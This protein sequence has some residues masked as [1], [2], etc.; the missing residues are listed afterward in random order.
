MGNG[1]NGV[2]AGNG[3]LTKTGTG[4]LQ[5]GGA[6]VFTGSLTVNNGQLRMANAQALGD[7]TVNTVGATLDTNGQNGTGAA[8]R[9]SAIT[10]GGTGVAGSL[11]GF[12]N[13]SVN[14]GGIGVDAGGTITIS[15]DTTPTLWVGPNWVP[16]PGPIQSSMAEP[17]N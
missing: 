8:V 11:G 16:A 9:P 10:I 13:T 12:I 17:A 2:L 14:T 4:I 7:G 5:L 15:G 1:A 3:N 6:N